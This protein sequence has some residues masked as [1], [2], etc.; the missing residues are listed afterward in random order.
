MNSAEKRPTTAFSGSGGTIAPLTSFWSCSAS[1]TKSEYRRITE[2]WPYVN[3]G[4]FVCVFT[5]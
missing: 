2:N 1:Q 4:R 3:S 5:L